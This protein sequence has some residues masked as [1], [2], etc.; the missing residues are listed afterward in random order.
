MKTE[1]LKSNAIL[2]L[3]YLI[4][5]FVPIILIPHIVKVLGLDVYGSL[6]IL[7]AIG[8][9]GAVIVQYAFQLT[10]PK[11]IAHQK[12]A[13]SLDEALFEITL[14]KGIL[15]LAVFF[16]VTLALA[17]NGSFSTVGRFGEVILFALPVAA[18]LNSAWFL[19]AVNKF[20]LTSIIS[21]SSTLL[22]IFIGF[23]YISNEIL[24]SIDVAVI[25]IFLNPIIVGAGTLVISIKYI[26][27][28]R[29]KLNFKGAIKEILIGRHLF[30][31]QS[32]SLAY[33]ASGPLIIGIILDS[34]SA[35]AYSVIEKVISAMSGGALLTYTVAYPRLA[36]EY[37]KNRQNY[38]NFLRWVIVFYLLST[39][40]IAVII[41]VWRYEVLDYLY[42][43]GSAY[44]P[45]LFFGL[46]WFVLGILGSAL[47]GHL[48]ISGNGGRIWIITLQVL[49]SSVLFGVFG[50][51][52]FGP[53]GWLAA[54]VLSQ[55]IVLFYG[56]KFWRN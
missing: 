50:V 4:A 1:L 32:F 55:L 17:L 2:A 36:T 53:S 23:N 28:R 51:M 35:G 21:I 22:T 19:Q 45:L 41:W 9:Y 34:K 44:L 48:V 29:F 27:V 3:Q 11:R 46:F 20:F 56:Y 31:S 52:Y 8:G 12:N 37:I 16:L 38:W 5:S 39:T 25:I 33:S 6:T 24:Y 10:G 14:A 18:A 43:Y 13:N 47:T 7:Q 49:L 30:L 42:G 26:K 40:L 54:L 15:L